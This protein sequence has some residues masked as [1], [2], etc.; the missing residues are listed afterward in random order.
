M[1]IFLLLHQELLKKSL[2]EVIT[3]FPE[4]VAVPVVPSSA[5]NTMASSHVT[6]DII[7]VVIEGL[8]TVDVSSQGRQS[9]RGASL[10]I[11]TLIIAIDSPPITAAPVEELTR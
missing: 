8:F 7:D 11:P 1:L 2:A 9:W 3:T 10:P 6:F 5:V 4:L